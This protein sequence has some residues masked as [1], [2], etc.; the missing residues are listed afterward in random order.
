MPPPL[1]S[2]L[3]AVKEKP[4]SFDKNKQVAKRGG[5]VAGNAKLETEKELG[6]S[7]VSDKKYLE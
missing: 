1:K 6:H 2:K 5:K 4:D 7:I 3:R